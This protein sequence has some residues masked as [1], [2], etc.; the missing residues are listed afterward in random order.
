MDRAKV[1]GLFMG[2]FSYFFHRLP[3]FFFRRHMAVQS[4]AVSTE[5]VVLSDSDINCASKSFL[6]RPRH[7]FEK[8]RAGRCQIGQKPSQKKA[9]SWTSLKIT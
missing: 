9:S 8:R 5:P 4:E 6:P 3:R 1:S 2:G 7:L